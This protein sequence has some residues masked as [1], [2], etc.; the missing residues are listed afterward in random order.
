MLLGWGN[1]F[2]TPAE[3]DLVRQSSLLPWL[4][5]GD[6][7]QRNQE[8][9]LQ[10][11]QEQWCQDLKKSNVALSSSE[12]PVAGTAKAFVFIVVND[13]EKGISSLEFKEKRIVAGIVHN[14]H[15]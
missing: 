5:N 11:F 9:V 7:F 14:D 2:L 13:F 6:V 15:F 8:L 10:N 3:N 4:R 1:F 12:T